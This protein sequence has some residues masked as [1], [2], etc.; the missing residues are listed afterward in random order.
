MEIKRTRVINFPRSLSHRLGHR[1]NL[2]MTRKP[3]STRSLSTQSLSTTRSETPPRRS[4]LQL[5]LPIL[6]PQPLQPLSPPQPQQLPQPLSSMNRMH[7]KSIGWQ[8]KESFTV[9][10]SLRKSSSSTKLKKS[11][12]TKPPAYARMHFCAEGFRPTRSPSTST[13]LIS[14][15][16]KESLE[17]PRAISQ[18]CRDIISL[19]KTRW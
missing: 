16:S 18:T 9:S 4:P 3:A 19:S 2:K 6:P 15:R 1:F 7:N 17:P 8:R 11:S 13:N 12:N 14:I 10:Q 5:L